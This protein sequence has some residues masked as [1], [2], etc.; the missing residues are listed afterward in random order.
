MTGPAFAAVAL[1]ATFSAEVQR[2]DADALAVPF[3]AQ[4]EIESAWR[5]EARSA[6]AA[7]LTQFT[8]LTY[9]GKPPKAPGIKYR[10]DPSCADTPVTDP[11]CAVRAQI[12]Y[13]RALLNSRTCRMFA[14]PRDRLRC[15]YRAYNGG[16]GW[17]QREQGAC[18]E[19]ADCNPTVMDHVR[20]VCLRAD[21]A[22]RE[23]RAYAPK[24]FAAMSHYKQ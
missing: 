21:W 7:G 8:P 19:L 20:R 12:V 24:I 4:I 1:L 15:A 10:T 9:D 17:I 14:S 3:A 22:C 23:N 5:P 2:A 18:A 11:A 6:Y 13:M 16:L